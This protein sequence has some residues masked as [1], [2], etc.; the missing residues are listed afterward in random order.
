MAPYSRKRKYGGG[1]SSSVKR[2]RYGS[3]RRA[4]FR[5]RGR[6]RRRVFRRSFAKRR[7][8]R[9]R[10]K[11]KSRR[12]GFRRR[13]GS[14]LVHYVTVKCSYETDV[15]MKYDEGYP[16][17]KTFKLSCDK[18]GSWFPMN[19]MGQVV[20]TRWKLYGV[21]SHVDEGVVGI[22]VVAMFE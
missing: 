21:K 15:V 1:Y 11:F 14:A 2:G 8:F 4:R 6:A 12:R 9:G 16:V 5:R 13:G 22:D 10:R 18:G 3:R 7:R 17:G 19:D 20:Y